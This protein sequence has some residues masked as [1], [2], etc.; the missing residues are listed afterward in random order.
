[1]IDMARF[2]DPLTLLN[3]ALVATIIVVIL[4]AFL[5][6]GDRDEKEDCLSRGGA[7]AVVGQHRV[8]I[9]KVSELRDDYLCIDYRG[10]RIQP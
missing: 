2:R 6:K 7:W 8:M 10:R 5:S 4:G 3:V 1:M 9:G